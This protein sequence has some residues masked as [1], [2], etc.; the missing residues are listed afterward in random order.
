MIFSAVR[1]T[2][3]AARFREIRE[4]LL[5]SANPALA[6]SFFFLHDGENGFL[7][8]HGDVFQW[9]MNTRQLTEYPGEG[10][11]ISNMFDENYSSAPLK[12]VRFDQAF[13]KLPYDVTHREYI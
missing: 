4:K 10:T 5:N 12:L 11:E 7:G 3:A 1:A 6:G 2:V 9:F 8:G 13:K